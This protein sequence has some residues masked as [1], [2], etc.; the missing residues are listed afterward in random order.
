[1]I[2]IDFTP[3]DIDALHSERFHH[4]HSRVQLKMEAERLWKFL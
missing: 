1:M 3:Q 2:H 4:P